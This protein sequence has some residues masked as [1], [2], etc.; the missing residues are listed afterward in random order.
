[1]IISIARVLGGLIG[2]LGM[3][4]F[5]AVV[6]PVGLMW[7]VLV[8][9][10]RVPLTGQWRQRFKEWRTRNLNLLRA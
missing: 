7:T 4:V 3:L 6:L 2:T 5:F 1:V 8:V 10:R 9:V